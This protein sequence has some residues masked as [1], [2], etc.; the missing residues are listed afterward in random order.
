MRLWPS[1]FLPKKIASSVMDASIRAFGPLQGWEPVDHLQGS[2][3]PSGPERP[4]KKSEK[5]L[6]GPP[7]P[8][9]PRVWKKARKSLESLEKVSK[10]SRKTF[11]RD[12]FQD[13]RGVRGRRPRETFFS[14]FFGVSQ[15]RRA[16]ETPVNGQRVPNPA[17][18]R[19]EVFP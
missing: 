8:G 15:A 6:P 16:R 17:E 3:G 1:G 19:H 11:S 14:D 10:R 5:S 4:P 2:L 12:F 18:P 9:P 7:A 13:F